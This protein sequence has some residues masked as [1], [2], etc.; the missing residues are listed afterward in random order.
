LVAVVVAVVR[1]V[2]VAVAVALALADAASP[3]AASWEP[4]PALRVLNLG[5]GLE[6]DV[7]VIYH[8]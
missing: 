8:L 1:K 6:F 3:A 4:S 7:K 5:T 2:A